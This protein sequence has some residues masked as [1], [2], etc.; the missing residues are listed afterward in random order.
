MKRN[1]SEF[2]IQKINSS[3]FNNTIPQNSQNLNFEY[4]NNAIPYNNY[5]NNI[6]LTDTNNQIN[7][8]NHNS[9][10]N[11][12]TNLESI[13]DLNNINNN[14]FNI[15][16]KQNQ[17]LQQQIKVLTKRIK[18][19]ENDYIKD[20]DRK[21]NQ[22]KEFSELETD[23]N[24][25]INNKDK[26]INSIKEE[27]NYLK[28][29]L[30]QMDKDIYIIKEEVKNLLL[31]KSEREQDV[32]K[33]SLNNTISENNDI[34]NHLIDLVKKYSNEIIYLKSQNEKL[35]NNL[36]LMSNNIKS[37]NN[38]LS[39]NEIEKIKMMMKKEEKSNF[40]NFVS[41]FAKEINEELFV[42]SQ[43]IETYLGNEYDKGYEIPSLINHLEKN[44]NSGEKLNLINFNIIKE[45]LEKSTIQLNS[46]INNKETEIIKL[47]NIIKEKDHQCNELKK[48]IIQIRQK[49]MELNNEKDKILL[50]QEQE[51]K[52]TLMNKNLIND[53]K[54]NEAS[55]KNNNILYLKNLYEI[56]QKEINSILSDINFRPY[57]DNLLSI[58]E[59]INIINNKNNINNNLLEE[60][61]NTSLIKI[62]EFI[63]ELKYDY[64]QIKNDNIKF[65]KE[66]TNVKNILMKG[67][68]I[69]N[70]NMALLEEYKYKIEEL[71][72]NNKLLREEMK[73][74]NDNNETK[75]LIENEI[76]ENYENISKENQNL[77]FNN[78]SLIN[79]L[80]MV[81]E[82]YNVLENENNQ[83][84]R[85]IQKI[86]NMEND[87]NDLKQKINDLS[88]DYQRLLKENNSLKLY[89]NS[90]NFLN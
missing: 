78:D 51:R 85:R 79:K 36:N 39:K 28:N 8:I 18:E 88:I 5:N 29:Y 22:L 77:K 11:T 6:S 19:Y 60:K 64:T 80:K 7:V 3:N 84:K 75:I 74:I 44:P 62:I 73:R 32:N 63:E 90:Q 89:L 82:N 10:E 68:N 13:N 46:I 12:N 43:W 4:S 2:D 70:N 42:I 67:N 9:N 40:D 55:S 24:N 87:D 86:K 33:Q 26:I 35:I 30:N 37:S 52:K 61:L 72:N 1:F 81:N 53:L 17:N 65:M 47:A 15:L 20:N 71:S 66:K 45:A 49:H 48:Q 76:L 59:N 16:Q 31:I 54:Q 14:N 21:A 83:L 25:Q 50:E 58:R 56:I 34:N 27:N 38:N 23:L 57:H 41:N 69:Q